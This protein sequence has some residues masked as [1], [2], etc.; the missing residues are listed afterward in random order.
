MQPHMKALLILFTLVIPLAGCDSY[1]PEKLPEGTVLQA[2]TEINTT[3]NRS[4]SVVANQS[5]TVYLKIGVL[6]DKKVRD[7]LIEGEL[8]AIASDATA[9]IIPRKLRVS[10]GAMP[11]S[12]I[13]YTKDNSKGISIGC[14]IPDPSGCGVYEIDKGSEVTVK[15]SEPIDL[16]GI[17]I[18][19]VEK[20]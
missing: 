13:A 3:L 19:S 17:V 18:T 16:S 6:L 9:K 11:L 7:L 4:V 8:T 5:E 20:N 10:A 2:G 12:G 15:L 1:R 14:G